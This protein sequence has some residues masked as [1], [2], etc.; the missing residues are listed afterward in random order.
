[1]VAEKIVVEAVKNETIIL[2]VPI[3]VK[4]NMDQIQKEH[5]GLVEHNTMSGKERKVLV[6]EDNFW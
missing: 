6:G 5:E 1:M 3:L 4:H 2:I